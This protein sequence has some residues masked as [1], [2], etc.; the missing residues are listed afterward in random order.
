MRRT[1]LLLLLAL[2]PAARA[3]QPAQPDALPS[4]VRRL[5]VERWNT[6]TDFRAVDRA[7]INATTEIVGNVAVLRGPLILAGHVT[8]TVLVINGDLLLMP[9]ARID[10]DL[11]V[12]GGDVEGRAAARIGGT[13]QIFRASLNYRE[14]GE[15]LIALND[16]GS[17]D[18]ESWWRR[19][20]RHHEG[21]WSEA[22]RIVQAG[23]YNRVEGLPIQIGPVMQRLTPWGSVRGD[24]A[25]IVRT[26]SSFQSDDRPDVGHTLRGEV[27]FGRDRGIGVGARAFSEVEPVESWQLSDLET[28]LAAFLARRD[29]RDYFQRHGARGVLTLYGARD[30]SLSATYGHERWSSR[31]L[32]NPFTLFNGERNWRDNP[33][34]DDGVFHVGTL[35]LQFD[36]RTDPDDPWAG[37]FANAD[38]ERGRGRDDGVVLLPGQPMSFTNYTRGFLDLRRYNRLGPTAQLNMRVVLAGWMGGDQLPLERR[39]SVDGPGTIPGFGFRSDQP[40]VDVGNCNVGLGVAGRPAI[41]D[42][43]ALAQVEYRGAVKLGFGGSWEDWPRLYRNTR[44][45]VNWVLFADAGRGWMIGD[46]GDGLHYP[47]SGLP[48]L[49]TFRTDVGVGLDVAGIGVYAAKALSST[50]EPA[51]FFVRLRHRF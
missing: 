26:G 9:T 19:I 43:I 25:A 30:L 38:V 47:S 21:D 42:R 33:R 5:V 36:T 31:R 27:R 11:L 16:D 40:G 24:A 12:V 50:K 13:T 3:Q 37:W 23:A 8:G 34:I 29:Y 4:A 20:E 7:E 51:N 44:G 35:S 39:F 28:A 18:E 49:S 48:G 10:G 41:C 2:T 46:S 15:R 45:A 17:R 1:F 32:R 6:N 22:F 14:Q